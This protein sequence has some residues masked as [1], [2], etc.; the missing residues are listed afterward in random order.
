MR[1]ISTAT[2]SWRSNMLTIGVAFKL[3]RAS[4]GSSTKLQTSNHFRWLSIV[5]YV[6]LWCCTVF[7]T[8]S[9]G[10]PWFSIVFYL[11]L[12]LAIVV[13]SF[14]C[15]SMNLECVFYLFLWRSIMF[16]C[17]Q[18][19]LK[20]GRLQLLKKPL[21]AR[22][23]RLQNLPGPRWLNPTIGLEHIIF[24]KC[25]TPICLHVFIRCSWVSAF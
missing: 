22:L 7:A 8:L 24:Q 16:L 20:Y 25:W 5:F 14:L 19:F 23:P 12:W 4:P 17:Y 10:L 18:V 21:Q 13:Y 6:C 9:I 15:V 1:D 2:R 3:Q 11:F